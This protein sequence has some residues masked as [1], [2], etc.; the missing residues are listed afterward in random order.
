MQRSRYCS[1][2]SEMGCEGVA[3]L[4]ANLPVCEDVGGSQLSKL[5]LSRCGIKDEGAKMVAAMLRRCL[6]QVCPMILVQSGKLLWKL[7]C[8][9]LKMN[10][11]QMNLSQLKSK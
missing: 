8:V 9:D 10:W 3:L 5:D 4:V 11:S 7:M 1:E 2:C 6:E